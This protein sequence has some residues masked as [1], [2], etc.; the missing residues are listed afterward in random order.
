MEALN[1]IGKKVDNIT[2]FA[3]QERGQSQR[4]TIFLVNGTE[5]VPAPDF[6]VALDST[7]LKSTLLDKVEMSGDQISFTGKGYGHGV[8]MSQWG[9]NKMATEGKKPEDIVNY[10]FKGIT[11][12]KRWE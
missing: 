4:T 10:Y 9:A 5:Q 12:E 8:G 7:K 2:Q 6:R 1:K 11:I 3:I